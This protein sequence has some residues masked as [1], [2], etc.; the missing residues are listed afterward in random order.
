[1]KKFVYTL[2][3][4]GAIPL[5]LTAC[6]EKSNVTDVADVM[7][8]DI[9][10][11]D[12]EENYNLSL[13]EL[14]GLG[15]NIKC[16]YDFSNEEA[17][18]KG[19]VYV[20]GNKMRSEMSVKTEGDGEIEAY[21]V[22]DDQY[23]YMWASNS[24]QGMRMSVSEEDYDY[25]EDMNSSDSSELYS[26]QDQNQKMDYKCLP[27]VP[28]NSKFDTPNDIDFIDYTEMLQDMMKSLEGME[29]PTQ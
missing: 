17:S 25:A 19:I 27:W 28:D 18:G 24:N 21:T 10:E 20:S 1:M 14:T 13:K 11:E 8:N 6:T 15:K 2:L 23:V 3:V 16:T 29:L 26:Y 7:N 4:L 22:S 5:T 12:M 9:T